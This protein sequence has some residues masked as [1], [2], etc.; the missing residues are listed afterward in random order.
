MV[1]AIFFVIC[2]FIIRSLSLLIQMFYGIINEKI[3]NLIENDCWTIS[4]PRDQSILIKNK[5]VGV[6]FD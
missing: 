6:N 4:H 5:L 3:K 1:L 2:L